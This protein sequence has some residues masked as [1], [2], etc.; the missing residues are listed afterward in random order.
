MYSMS[1]YNYGIFKAKPNE[2]YSGF[3]YSN[4]VWAKQR[5]DQS[6]ALIN[7]TFSKCGSERG[8]LSCAN[9]IELLGP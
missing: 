8:A 4:L 3:M 7:R 6:L 1:F 2:E 9:Y 5:S